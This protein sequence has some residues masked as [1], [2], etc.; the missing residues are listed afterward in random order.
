MR[1]RCRRFDGGITVIE[2]AMIILF[3]LALFV[4]LAWR[5][6]RDLWAVLPE[7]EDEHAEPFTKAPGLPHNRRGR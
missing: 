5:A 1:V 2:Y 4:W 6:M 3:V 7:D